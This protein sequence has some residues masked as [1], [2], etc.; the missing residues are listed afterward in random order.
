MSGKGMSLPQHTRPRLFVTF[1]ISALEIL[2]LTY[3]HFRVW[4]SVVSSPDSIPQTH[5]DDFFAAKM[6]LVSITSR[7]TFDSR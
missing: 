7:W 6:I 3:F 1:Y 2:L 5:F 4:R